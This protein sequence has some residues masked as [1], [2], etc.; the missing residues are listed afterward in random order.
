MTEK[1]LV[2]KAQSVVDALNGLDFNSAIVVMSAAAEAISGG[3]SRESGIAKTKFEEGILWA[4]RAR[5]VSEAQKIIERERE[6]EA[7]L[8]EMTVID[9]PKKEV[10]NRSSRRKA[11]SKAKKD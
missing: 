2:E 11:A 6:K 5:E 3:A 8:S 9:A 10:E 7:A 4:R 1:T